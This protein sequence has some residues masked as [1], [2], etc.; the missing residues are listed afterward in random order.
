MDVLRLRIHL[1]VHFL[2]F[3]IVLILD[4]FFIVEVLA[5]GFMLD[6]LKAMGVKRVPVLFSCHVMYDHGSR[7]SWSFVGYGITGSLLISLY[8]FTKS[9]WAM[10]EDWESLTRLQ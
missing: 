3:L 6:E 10:G 8:I 4:P 1:L 5:V 2:A 9:P 7:G